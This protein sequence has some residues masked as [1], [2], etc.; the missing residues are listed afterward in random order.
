[1]SKAIARLNAELE[2]RY[3]VLREIG[4][5]GMATVY[6]AEDLKH[7]R[8]VAVKV[9]HA[10]LA[11]SVGSERFLREIRVSARLNH[12]HILTLIDSGQAG[13]ALFYVIPFVDGESIRAK[14]DREKRVDLQ[15][16]ATLI[17]QV[18]SALDYAHQQGVIHRDIKPENILLHRGVAM[19]SDFGIAV[20][21]QAA[22]ADRLTEEGASL[23]TPSYM[24]P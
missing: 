6:L 19:V 12:P 15:E 20:G 7:G 16:T 9:L 5:G 22:Q 11:S 13:D 3:R 17:R 8:D 2:G 18:A 1:M 23:G 24:S 4:S 10:R 14:L 21:L